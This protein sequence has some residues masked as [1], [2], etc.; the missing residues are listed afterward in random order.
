MIQ[1]L[2]QKDRSFI[3]T[4]PRK[5]QENNRKTMTSRAWPTNDHSQSEKILF[6]MEARVF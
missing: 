4:K 2:S 6:E 3:E 1:I 5:K